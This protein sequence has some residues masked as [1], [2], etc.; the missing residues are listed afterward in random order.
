LILKKPKILVFVFCLVFCFDAFSQNDKDS[1]RQ[2]KTVIVQQSR[3][4]DY[5]IAVY[6]LPVDSS[7]L[8]LSSNGSLTDLL[9]KQGFG[10]IRTY[11]PGGLASPSFRGTGS[12]HT[13][14]LWNGINLVSPLSGQLDL[15]LLPAGLFD[16][17]TVQ[18]GGSTSLS[19]NG[20][21]GANIHLNNNLNFNEGLRIT[22]SSC[23]GSF[24]SQHYDAG[25]RLSNKSVGMSTKVF[26][27]TSDNDF[28]FTNQSVFPA[29]TQRRE[30]SAFEQHGLLQQLHWNSQHSGIVSLKL[31]YQKSHYEIPNPTGILRPWE[32]TEEN[33]FYRSLVGWNFS[34]E[35]FDFNYQAAF[36]RQ[37]L[38]Y[39]DPVTH[40]YSLNRYNS[41]IHN[42]ETNINFQRSAQL[43]FG[44][45]Y[46]WEQGIVDDFGDLS[47]VRNRIALF[48]A[49]KLEAFENWIFAIS[50]REE[51]VNGD[52]MPFSPRVST[53]YNVSEKLNVFTNV[54]RNYRIPTF[55]DL[56]WKGGGARGNPDLK[57]EISL[58]GEAG[59]EFINQLIS[60]KSVVFDNHVDN[61]IQW[62]PVAGQ[63]W[64]PQNIKKVWSRGVESKLSI[65]ERIGQV[66][67]SL[68]GQY[69]F[70]KSTNKS[71]YENGNPGEKGK[72]LLLT[73]IHEG[74][75]TVEGK[76]KNFIL[77]IVNSYTGK[78]F[79]DSDNSP[80]NSVKDYLI[81]NLWL[82]KVVEQDKVT[83]TFTGEI[84]NVL[85]VEYVGRPGYP[86][87]GR[88]Y[89]AGIKIN[90]NKP[91]KL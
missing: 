25:I 5:I 34:K 30:H 76:W 17:A 51:L 24:G 29:E 63:V 36:I 48:S 21:I 50:G 78:Q 60:F 32:A 13:A 54:S 43:T 1:V 27:N 88:N 90:F 6:E 45:H 42:F 73:P 47:P 65:S 14:V 56:Y 4:N 35:T 85:N 26:F 28:K 8:A 82:I 72:Q 74:T 59:V 58:S 61:W 87:P 81:T 22:G 40:Q 38:D 46:T 31:W 12:S 68:A 80:Y 84:N 89:K 70:T 53:K 83:L 11:G 18:T 91:S 20:S 10:H 39:A 2:L 86:M 66:H 33:K 19:G 37:D 71:I 41:T 62:S 49:Y 79:N 7:V 57:T 77:R 23:I 69:S 55:N 44:I 15:S 75:A 9:R 67:S 52:A 3:L 64:M 16:D